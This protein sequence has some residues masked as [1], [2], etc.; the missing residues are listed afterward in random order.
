MP[1]NLNKLHNCLKTM[2]QIYL[3]DPTISVRSSNFINPL[4]DYC[5]EE[6]Y[7]AVD[8]SI[9][10]QIINKKDMVL[11]RGKTHYPRVEIEPQ[12]LQ[13]MQEAT[14]YG[15]HKN[16]DTDVVLSN[17]ANGPQIIIGVRSQMS[18]VAKNIEN[19]YEG[20]IG[21]CISLHDRFPMAVIGYVYLLPTAP[22]KPERT[23]TVDLARAEQLYTKITGRSNW[24]DAHDKYEHFAFLKVDFSKNLPE[25]LDTCDVLQIN[26]FFD[27]L[28]ATYNERNVFNQ[29]K[30]K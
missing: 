11:P 15:S 29:I 14:L 6:L 28:L 10:I 3:S 17:F 19:Y 5:V 2:K 20:I 7:D 24:R 4:H 18:S 21:E 27:K 22:I 13:L 9:G 25:L 23:E 26:T 12:K 1:A 30:V 8:S 16:K